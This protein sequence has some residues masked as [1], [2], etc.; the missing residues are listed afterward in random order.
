M[1]T[2][3]FPQGLVMGVSGVR[4]IVGEG[5]VPEVMARLAAAAHPEGRSLPL[6]VLQG[7]SLRAGCGAQAGAAVLDAAMRCRCS[8]DAA[9][10]LPAGAME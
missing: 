4:G 9:C 1:T 6:Y 2:P 8:P 7:V 5:L 10:T 3:R